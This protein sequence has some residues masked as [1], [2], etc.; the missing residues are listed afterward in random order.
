MSANLAATRSS[1]WVISHVARLRHLPEC[2]TDGTDCSS[3]S[4]VVISES[5]WEVAVS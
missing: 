2:T 5:N 3:G 4:G 1:D